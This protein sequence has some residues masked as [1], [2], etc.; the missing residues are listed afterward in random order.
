[1]L[2]PRRSVRS[3]QK[4]QTESFRCVVA[5][6]G[7]ASGQGVAVLQTLVLSQ[8]TLFFSSS[9][10]FFTS[11][12]ICLSVTHTTDLQGIGST[13]QH[14][15]F[16]PPRAPALGQHTLWNSNQVR[17]GQQHEQGSAAWCACMQL[18]GQL[19]PGGALSPQCCLAGALKPAAGLRLWP[20]HLQVYVP[21]SHG[22]EE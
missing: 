15:C 4:P 20:T 18:H 5:T 19:R 11:F 10:F 13:T 8:P 14:I 7:E 22:R 6:W 1:M 3:N 2:F 12:Q 9:S 16:H 17:A 21:N